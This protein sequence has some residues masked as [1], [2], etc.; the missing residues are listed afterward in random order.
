[1]PQP[2]AHEF[3]TAANDTMPAIGSVLC[4][5]PIPNAA[6]TASLVTVTVNVANS[7]SEIAHAIPV[8]HVRWFYHRARRITESAL[9]EGLLVSGATE[10]EA[11]R[12]AR[13]L[14]ARID[15]L[16]EACGAAEAG[17]IKTA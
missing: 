7:S 14:R 15:A 13:A 5:R 4:T 16:G 8:S 12:F 11:A 9:R 1:M 10:D 3:R 2:Y 6:L 17:T